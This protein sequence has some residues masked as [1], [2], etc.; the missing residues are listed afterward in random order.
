MCAIAPRLRGPRAADRSLRGEPRGRDWRVP[1]GSSISSS[2]VGNHVPRLSEAADSAS[3]L[4]ASRA[5]STYLRAPLAREARHALFCAPRVSCRAPACLSLA[6]CLS[7][8]AA[9]AALNV[10]RRVPL[11]SPRP[12]SASRSLYSVHCHCTLTLTTAQCTRFT[13]AV[14]AHSIMEASPSFLNVNGGSC[15]TFAP[16]RLPCG[17]KR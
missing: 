3:S 16:G 4:F 12:P 10:A 8:S 11:R 5:V 14:H 1:R 9:L 13:I 15:R 6:A 17:E 7:L 2:T